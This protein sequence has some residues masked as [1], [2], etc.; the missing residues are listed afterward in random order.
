M[1]LS[2]LRRATAR[3][4][5]LST[6]LATAVVGT[7][8]L[9]APA[10]AANRVTPGHFTGYGFDQCETQSQEVMDT[11]LTHS[12]YWA[13][14]IYIAGDNRH[15]GDDRQEHLTAEWVSTQLANGWK[16]L[17]ITVGPQAPC[18][19][20]PKKKV[21]ID[22]DP[23]GDFAAARQQGRLEA[24][25]TVSRAQALGIASKSTLW[26]DI[27]AFDT[28]NNRCRNS[29]LAFLSGWTEKLHDLD[30]VSGVY[31][32]AAR[33]MNALDDARVLE[34][35]RFTM[36]DRI[37][38]AEWVDAD[39]YRKPPTANPPSLYSA[40]LRD[41]GWFP[42]GRMRQYR[43]G[44]DETYGGVTVN[45]DTN[46][47]DLGRGTRP[48]RAPR[49]CD[50]TVV[51]FPAYRR[52]GPGIEH[53]QVDALQCFLKRKK[54][55]DAPITGVYDAATT[56]AVRAFRESRGQGISGRMLR[57][58]WTTL[59]SEGRG[60]VL[61]IGSGGNTV[62]RLQRSL[63]AAVHA[64]LAVDGIFGPA[65]TAAVRDYQEAVGLRRTGVVAW[66][67]WAELQSGNL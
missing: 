25:D 57:R 2:A 50:G 43:G 61:K 47:L 64:G 21:R 29:T 24:V 37:W 32:S 36:P 4:V 53:P 67:T 8:A 58:T 12:P 15:C 5:V 30:Y 26:N 46:Y 3:A 52:L 63:N 51:D 35:G 49:F 19:V 27:E 33:G 59:L 48:G 42:G 38:V 7:V 60:P 34:P 54:L 55:Y 22:N 23:A 10:E 17:P 44:H 13:V 28:T 18:Y 56:A 62:R 16:L 14:G 41:D 66:D 40:Y 6:S 39:R 1:L 11:W 65:T 20:N 31:M 9:S 45:I